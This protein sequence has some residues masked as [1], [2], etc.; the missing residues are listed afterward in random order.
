ML[1]VASTSVADV[2][3]TNEVAGTVLERVELVATN[4]EEDSTTSVTPSAV[5]EGDTNSLEDSN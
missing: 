2:V 1:L 3:G 4:S 5:G